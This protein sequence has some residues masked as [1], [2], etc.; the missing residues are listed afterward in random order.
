MD[1]VISGI[2]RNA[3]KRIPQGPGCALADGHLSDS[4]SA[5]FN[6]AWILDIDTTIAALYGHQKRAHRL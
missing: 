5:S 4:V 1:K 3:P 6:A 2:S